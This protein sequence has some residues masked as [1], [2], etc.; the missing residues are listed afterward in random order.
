MEKICDT[1]VYVDKSVDYRGFIHM[2][3]T[4][5]RK[6]RRIGIFL[7]LKRPRYP[8]FSTESVNEEKRKIRTVSD[9]VFNPIGKKFVPFRNCVSVNFRRGI[10]LVLKKL[11]DI[12][13][14]MPYSIRNEDAIRRIIL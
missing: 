6:K 3:D 9:C 8:H 11:L 12:Q 13:Y 1:C 4:Y 14:Y 7:H 2:S 5:V 10:F